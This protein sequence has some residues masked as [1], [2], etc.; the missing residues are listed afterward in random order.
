MDIIHYEPDEEILIE[1]RSAHIITGKVVKQF[2]D[3]KCLVVY[4]DGKNGWSHSVRAV[5]PQARMTKYIP[6]E[7]PGMGVTLPELQH[8]FDVGITPEQLHQAYEMSL[9]LIGYPVI[10]HNHIIAET[11]D[12]VL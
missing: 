7:L 12:G 8:A 1:V 2:D 10:I 4:M 9:A 11:M 3:G 6:A 5:I